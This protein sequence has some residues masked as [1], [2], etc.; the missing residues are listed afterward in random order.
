MDESVQ[1]EMIVNL[2]ADILA[3]HSN[4][5][6]LEGYFRTLVSLSKS[7]RLDVYEDGWGYAFFDLPGDKEKE[8]SEE[9]LTVDQ[10]LETACLCGECIY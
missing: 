5:R 7:S 8:D 4:A 2:L 1:E 10:V 9:P 6:E 3:E